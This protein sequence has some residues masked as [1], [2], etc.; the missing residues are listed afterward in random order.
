MTAGGSSIPEVR[1]LLA[2]LAVGRRAAE[3]GTAF[4][5]G[6]AAIASTAASLVTVEIDASRASGAR[7]RLAALGNV[8]LLVGDWRDLLPPRGPY[9]LVFADSGD[10]KTDEAVAGLVAPGGLVVMDDLTPGRPPPDRVRDFWLSRSDFTAAEI[11]TT[12]RT[13]ALIAARRR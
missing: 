8:E 11:L 7:A 5:E 1:Q 13:A 3:L 12:V 10:S 4:G 2:V 6:A 9:D